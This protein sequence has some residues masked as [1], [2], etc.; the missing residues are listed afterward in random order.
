MNDQTTSI[1]PA[2]L[3]ALCYRQFQTSQGQFGYYDLNILADQAS[4]PLSAMPYAIRIILENLLRHAQRDDV[5]TE[6]PIQIL[7]NYAQRVGKDNIPLMLARV[8]AQDV[9]GIPALIDLATMRDAMA[10]AGGD[11]T[12]I[13]PRIPVELIVDHSLEVDYAGRHDAPILNV[14]L[15]HKRNRERYT[16]LKWA[17]GAVKNLSIVP[18][19][20]GILH[21]INLEALAR[22]VFVDETQNPPLAYPDTLV[23]TDSHTAMINAIGVLGWGVGGI[24]AEAAMLGEPLPFILPATVGVRLINRPKPGVTATDIVLTLTQ[25]LRQAKVVESFVEF[26]GP[27]LDTDALTLED[28]ATLS[29]MSPEYGSTCG[30]FPVDA[31]T[32]DYLR[33]SGRDEATIELVETYCKLQGL[34]RDAN[35][36]EPAFSRVIELDLSTIEPSAAGPRRPHE[37]VNLS[38]IPASFLSACPAAEDTPAPTAKTVQLDHGAVILAAITSCTNTSNPSAMIAAG[39]LARK[40]V[41]KGLNARPW[42]KTSFTPGSRVVSDYLAAS[43]LQDD[44]DQLGFHLAGYGCASCGGG[45]GPLAPEIQQDI[46][47]RKLTVSAVL[48]GNRNFEGRIHPLARAN[49]LLSPALVVAYAIAGSVRIDLTKDPLAYTPDGAPVY[50]SDIWPSNTEIKAI[51]KQCVTPD[52][53]RTQYQNITEGDEGWNALPNERGTL[54]D[55]DADSSY[56]RRP[57]YVE[58]RPPITGRSLQGARPLLVLGDSVT[59]DNISPAD[60]IRPETPAGQYLLASGVPKSALHTFIARRGNHEVMMRG[61]FTGGR[62]HNELLPQGPEGCTLI[63]PQGQVASIYDAA[64]HYLA[65]KQPVVVVA[66]ME[67]GTGSSRDWAAKGTR[68]LGVQAVLAGSFERIH[69]SNLVNMGVLPLQFEPGVTRQSLGITAHSTFDIEIPDKLAPQ[70]WLN[71]RIQTDGQTQDIKLLARLNTAHEEAVWRKGGIL[72]TMLDRILHA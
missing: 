41:A 64:M 55:W 19:G 3:Q 58:Q 68:L 32:I 57:P 10:Q 54:Y 36:P 49:Y 66:G 40:A 13:N 69:R 62:L 14:A 72:P 30:L 2:A 38:G 67:Y 37:H 31:T 65:I 20:A 15:E 22:V 28:R 25:Q 48:S 21:Q 1:T 27:A 12:T 39:L 7:Q 6:L 51:E 71:C 42:V 63:E 56:V 24:E 35:S 61:T 52:R 16:F 4:A 47:T 60:G 9:S 43:G 11:P 5:G 45:S 34:W 70:S 53:F 33:R 23:G 18:P 50:L 44:L 17:Q 26:T 29:N 46:E 8:M 59:T